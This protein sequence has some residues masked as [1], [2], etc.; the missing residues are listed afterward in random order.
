MIVCGLGFFWIEYDHTQ[1]EK[2]DR[3]YDALLLTYILPCSPHSPTPINI[4][5]NYKTAI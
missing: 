5:K 4:V 2:I 1:F 3:K